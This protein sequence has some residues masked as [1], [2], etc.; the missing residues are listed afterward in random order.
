MDIQARARVLKIA[1]QEC[2]STN[3]TESIDFVDRA[4]LISSLVDVHENLGY[5]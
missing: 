4:C 2:A 3:D 5:R 1:I